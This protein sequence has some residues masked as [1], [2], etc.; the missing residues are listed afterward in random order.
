MID[1]LITAPTEEPI[2][3]A[4]AKAHLRITVSDDDT[5][6]TAMI[7]AAREQAELRTGRALCTQ[8][9]ETVADTFDDAE[10]LSRS[11]VQSIVNVK[12]L[13]TA[14]VQ[15]TLSSGNYVLDNDATPGRVFLAYGA[16]WP[17]TYAMPNA[18]RVRYLAGY[19]TAA[20]VP[21]SIKAWMLLAIGS[22]YAL[23]ETFADGRY[24]PLPDRFWHS[25]LDP[26]VIYGA[27]T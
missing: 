6:I 27:R 15:Q 8:T 1:K 7:V 10:T 19:G 5:R 2:T 12:Y 17:D 20:D 21:Q 4:I 9:W 16:A 26:F 13:D 23:A 25:L 11:P 3:L 24:A 14:G 18:V 22:M